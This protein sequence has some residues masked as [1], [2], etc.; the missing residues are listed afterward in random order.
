[1]TFSLRRFQFS[2]IPRRSLDSFLFQLCYLY[3]SKRNGK[4]CNNNTDDITELVENVTIGSSDALQ[5][6]ILLANA[7]L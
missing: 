3:T 4:L 7:G 1:M 6:T 5:E 2:H